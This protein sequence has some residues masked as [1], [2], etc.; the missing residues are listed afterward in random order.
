M[1][2]QDFNKALAN[3][4]GENDP[5]TRNWL[6]TTMG[7]MFAGRSTNQPIEGICPVCGQTGQIAKRRRNASYVDDEINWMISCEVC[8]QEDYDQ[9]ASQW[10]DYYSMVM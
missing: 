3:A 2:E 10:E 7:R 4:F 6:S 5:Q 1:D 8:F 9:L